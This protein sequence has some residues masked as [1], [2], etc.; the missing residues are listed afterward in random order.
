MNDY[1]NVKAIY[2]NSSLVSYQNRPRLYWTNIPGVKEPLDKHIDFQD[3]MERDEEKC[4][5]YKVNRTPSREKMWNNGLGHT[6]IGACNNVTRS[7]KI[8]CITRKQDRFP[9]SGL[10]EFEDFCRYL[11]RSEIEGGQTLPIG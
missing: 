9:N 6:C 11:T 1:L 8:F 3:Y 7:N 2:I 4:R 5:Q 10:I